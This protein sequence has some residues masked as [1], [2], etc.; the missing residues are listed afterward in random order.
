LGCRR[1][2]G[3]CHKINL[4]SL[5]DRT[6]GENS[7]NFRNFFENSNSVTKVGIREVCHGRK[8]SVNL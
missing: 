2:R 1:I 7:R 5:E 3:V 8:K 4:R 6:L